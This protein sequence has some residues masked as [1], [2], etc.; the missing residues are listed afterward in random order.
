MA[1]VA[2]ARPMVKK[3]NRGQTIR[4]QIT[5]PANDYLAYYRGDV[6]TVVARANDGR[7]IRFPADVLRPVLTHKGIDGEFLLKIDE[8]DK[9]VSLT[10][11]A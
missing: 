10:P 6:D 5:I 11:V 1:A 3:N 9:F 8:N 2:S 4:L 7:V